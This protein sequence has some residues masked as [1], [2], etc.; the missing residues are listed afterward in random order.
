MD[1]PFVYDRY[2]TGKYF[3]GRR[4]ECNILS[5]LLRQ[6]E[7]VVIYEPPKSGKMSVVQ[8]TLFQMRVSG[9]K[10]DVFGVDLFNVRTSVSF[11]LK[12]G[13]SV[14]RA[15]ASSPD[16]YQA[17]TDRYLSNTCFRF[18]AEHFAS[19]DQVLVAIGNTLTGDDI[20][21]ILSLPGN[22]A[23]EKGS[24]AI[25]IVEEFHNIMDTAEYYEIFKAF[26][27]VMS[28]GKESHR[29]SFVLVGSSV[30]AM[31]Y[32]FEE[33][34]WFYRLVEHLPLYPADE[35]EVV[36][37]LVKGY[38][39]EGKV[40]DKNDAAG[41]CRIFRYNLWYVNHFAS[42]C[43]SLSRGY[44]NQGI[45]LEALNT[46]I[47]IHSPKFKSIVN[48][49]TEHQMSLLRATLDGVIR[50]SATDVVEKYGLNSSANVKRVKDAL[51]KKEVITFNEKD[52]PVF[53]DPLFEYW[54]DKHYLER[55]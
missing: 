21:A 48:S 47:S 27:A 17:I 13:N 10:F 51:K 11:L 24:K 8:Q 25:M 35:K 20:S 29:C 40:L 46:L 43:N 55:V 53:L 50:F 39:L 4:S 37:H 14:I 1:V 44:I 45:M 36:D 33:R 3:V 15:F 18:D 41:V 52:E 7:N 12:F 19:L 2:V 32:I 16:E 54:L 28:A 34:K 31:K 5:N 49:L 6:G 22:L 38:L 26:E 9:D 23:A 42:I 30:N